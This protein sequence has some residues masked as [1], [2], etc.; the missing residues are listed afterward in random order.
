MED[1]GS[2]ELEPTCRAQGSLPRLHLS[3]PRTLPPWVP[4]PM[5]EI[6]GFFGPLLMVSATLEIP[7]VF[8][9]C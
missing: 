5:Q 1:S 6:S 9:L 7:E 4:F 8:F 3:P 2:E